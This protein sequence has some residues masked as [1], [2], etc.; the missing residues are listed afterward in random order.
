MDESKLV[1]LLRIE[2]AEMNRQQITRFRAALKATLPPAVRKAA[3]MAKKPKPK[4]AV[5]GA[6]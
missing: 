4:K 5:D 2:L 1:D 3:R 6:I